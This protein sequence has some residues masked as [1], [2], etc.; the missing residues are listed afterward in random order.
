MSSTNGI[1]NETNPP[2]KTRFSDRESTGKTDG[3]SSPIA[4]QKTDPHADSENVGSRPRAGTSPRGESDSTSENTEPKVRSSL[5]HNHRAA[6]LES[7]HMLVFVRVEWT[8]RSGER[9]ACIGVCGS[10]NTTT[11]VI[12]TSRA[13]QGAVVHLVNIDHVERVELSRS[14]SRW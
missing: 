12:F 8:A 5:F 1:A 14:R 11:A 7:L 4:V 6:L 2:V 13:S 10:L 3:S 9:C